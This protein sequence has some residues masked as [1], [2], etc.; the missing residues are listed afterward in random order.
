MKIREYWSQE[1]VSQDNQN[2]H[3]ASCKIALCNTRN[4]F[5]V[6]ILLIWDHLACVILLLAS[7]MHLYFMNII[8]C[9]KYRPTAQL[10]I[11]TQ[12]SIVWL[13]VHKLFPHLW[14]FCFHFFLSSIISRA[15]VNSFLQ[16]TF[17]TCT[18]TSSKVNIFCI[19]VGCSRF[20]SA[21]EVHAL[22][23]ALCGPKT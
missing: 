16:T 6:F 8:S 5:C 11:I 9:N 4:A 17:P 18:I 15:S 12:Y 22:S 2:Y 21:R 7:F 3:F 23:T 19:W 1:I 10:L 13:Y 20:H 14:I